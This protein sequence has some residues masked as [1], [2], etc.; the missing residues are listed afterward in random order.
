[1][2]TMTLSSCH[3]HLIYKTGTHDSFF[4][5][6]FSREAA[7]SKWSRFI[8]NHCFPSS[9][10]SAPHINSALCFHISTRS[11]W[12]FISSLV[13]LHQCW[14]R[15][16]SSRLLILNSMFDAKKCY[17]VWARS[18]PRLFTVAFILLLWHRVSV[19]RKGIHSPAQT[20]VQHWIRPYKY[21]SPHP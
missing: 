1:M 3:F 8:F 10:R 5:K 7:D 12:N 20:V 4:T 15:S 2:P 11:S 9:L 13:Y 6:L 14:W 18:I 21:S 16:Y 17:C 19:G